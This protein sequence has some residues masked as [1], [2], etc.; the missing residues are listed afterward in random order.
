MILGAVGVGI[1]KNL[2]QATSRLTEVSEIIQPDPDPEGWLARRY[3]LYEVVQE[4]L[5]PIWNDMRELHP[6]TG[7]DAPTVHAHDRK[8]RE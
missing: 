1:Y 7:E 6:T 3:E 2:E 4:R 5:V 8:G